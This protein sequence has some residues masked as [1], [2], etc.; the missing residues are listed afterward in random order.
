MPVYKD[1]LAAAV[2]YN[3]QILP[4]SLMCG[5]IVLAVV[6]ANPA[7]L[8]LTAGAAVTQLLTNTVGR[9]LMRYSPDGAVITSSLDACR[10]GFV[11]RS[12]E[13]LLGHTPD[14]FW[15]PRAPSVYLATVGFFAGWGWALSQLYKEEI[16]A[17][18]VSRSTVT[19]M[20]V[21]SFLILA[22]A[23]LFRLFSG[24]D[25]FL[26]AMGGAALG[27]AFGYFGAITLGYSTNRRATN[28]W[29][30]P[31]LRDRINNGSAVYVCDAAPSG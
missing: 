15:H 2:L 1:Y 26:G 28:I 16:D 19:G 10:T 25:S 23:I 4:E 5:M 13:R 18:V 17:G 6:L 21:V 20:G 7:L 14:Q 27:V 9:L 12:W 3:L 11:G 24:C 29:G 8:S 22:T 30:I 31:L